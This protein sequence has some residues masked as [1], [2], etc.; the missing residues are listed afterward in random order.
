MFSCFKEISDNIKIRKRDGEE[1]LLIGGLRV[2][3]V[4]QINHKNSLKSIFLNI[5]TRYVPVLPG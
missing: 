4:E 5:I 2:R 1:L 3:I